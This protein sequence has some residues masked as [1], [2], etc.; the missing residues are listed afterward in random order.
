MLSYNGSEAFLISDKILDNVTYDSSHHAWSGS[1]MQ[2]WLY[3]IFYDKAFS[4][5]EERAGVKTTRVK[6][7]DSPDTDDD[8]FLLSKDEA[9]NELYF[10]NA[11]ER[12]AAGTQ[13]AKTVVNDSH[14]LDVDSNGCSY[15]WLR[16]APGGTGGNSI[17]YVVQ[18][19]GQI[20]PEQ[21]TNKIFGVRP[22][23]TVDLSSPI[24]NATESEINWQIGSDASFLS[25]STWTEFTKYREGFINKLPT[26]GNFDTRPDGKV[27]IG[28]LIDNGLYKVAT[29]SIPETTKGDISVKPIW[30]TA[31]QK[32]INYDLYIATT[33][34]YGRFLSEPPYVYTPGETLTLPDVSTVEDPSGRIAFS[35]QI[36]GVDVTEIASTSTTDVEVKAIFDDTG[37]YKLDFDMG[38]GHLTGVATPSE[39]IYGVE[40]SLPASTSVVAPYGREFSH[41]MLKGAN[42]NIINPNTATISDTQRGYVKVVA[43]YNFLSYRITWDLGSGRF[44]SSFA[45]PSTYQYGTGLKLPASTSIIPPIGYEFNHWEIGGVATTSI[46]KT[47]YG[48][49]HVVAIYN[50][51]TYH[52]NW[53]LDDGTTGNHGEWDGTAGATSYTYTTEYSLP[54]NIIGPT[55]RIF[56]NWEIEGIATT[57]IPVGSTGDK[58]FNAKYRNATYSVTWHD[59]DGNDINWISGFTATASYTYSE[60]MALP[61]TESIVLPMRMEFDYWIIRRAGETDIEYATSIAPSL[62]GDVDIIAVYKYVTYTINY[63][64]VILDAEIDNNNV[65]RIYNSADTLLSTPSKTNYK[66]VG[67][68]RNYN[69]TTHEYTNQYTG[70]D[71]IYVDGMS[72]YTI[73]AKWQVILTY[74][75]NGHGSLSP[76]YEYVDL[77]DTTTLPT[78]SDVTGYTFDL[79][80]SW[81][82]GVDTSTAT[83]IGSAGSIYTVT[84]P[85]VLFAHWDE[86]IYNVTYHLN[87]GTWK[88]GAH[89]KS[90]RSYTERLTLP[91][92]DDIEKVIGTDTYEFDG[93]YDNIN[94]AGTKI[95]SVEANT[96]SEKEFWLKWNEI[97]TPAP[98]PTPYDPGG[99]G[100]NSGGSGGGG[101]NSA[102]PITNNDIAPAVTKIN[103]LKT[104]KAAVVSRQITWVYEPITNKFKMNINI[105]EQSIPASDGFY[106][107]SSSIEQNVN[108]TTIN[109][110][111]TATYYF[112]REG[113]MVTGWIETVDNKWCYMNS[114]KNAQEGAM[115]FGWYQIQS[116]WY[117]FLADGIMLANTTTPDGFVVGAD[118]AWV[119]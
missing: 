77:W 41:W 20:L 65:E 113:N 4:F 67:W 89:N 43:V 31:G 34:E 106:L 97:P 10:S 81:Y 26:D 116:K 115:V 98:T 59:S 47:D 92:S 23:I 53:N 114:T 70:N 1:H 13:Y 21:V 44:I 101:G 91:T 58:E 76:N 2:Y 78:L 118:G 62:T 117:Y 7:P 33:S 108:G 107:V 15:Y 3:S 11:D 32:L 110:P 56:T 74:N 63:D 39:Y 73:Y 30:G 84:E 109:I 83:L 79:T 22:A 16:Q 66:F 95:T 111:T 68:Y 54:T 86:N 50:L 55:G 51:S 72:T 119:Q 42:G 85:K 27:L 57:S 94:L 6:T 82:D 14:T 100:G 71:D 37:T 48:N 103:Q 69:A 25:E 52:I 96:N 104:I 45:T 102:G 99:N 46:T 17:I 64:T 12:K 60:G 90:T 24:F 61:S 40:T 8:V 75:I 36:N 28:W 93:W 5:D 87:G 80:N 112:D 49:K 18:P 88:V 29:Y 9:E 38:G 105:G 35:W 19:D